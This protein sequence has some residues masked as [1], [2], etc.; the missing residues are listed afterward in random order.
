M[1]SVSEYSFSV[2]QEAWETGGWEK[3]SFFCILSILTSLLP[4]L[5][6]FCTQEKKRRRNEEEEAPEKRQKAPSPASLEEEELCSDH[7]AVCSTKVC[8]WGPLWHLVT[9]KNVPG[10]MAKQGVN[11]AWGWGNSL[12]R[13]P[14]SLVVDLLL[15]LLKLLEAVTVPACVCLAD[16]CESKSLLRMSGN[17]VKQI[18]RSALSFG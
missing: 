17:R 15:C 8:V 1:V 10:L 6:I 12:N 11:P 13:F 9:R 4:G 5:L 7:T 3:I 18:N 2:K 16:Q 14:S